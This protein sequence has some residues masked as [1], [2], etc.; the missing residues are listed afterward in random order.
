MNKNLKNE[1]KMWIRN[2]VDDV[3]PREH[4]GAI[5][6]TADKIIK[7]VRKDYL[8]ELRE[9]LEVGISILIGKE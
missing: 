1:I 2:I 6:V 5:D 3:D 8:E 4:N 9:D 7:T